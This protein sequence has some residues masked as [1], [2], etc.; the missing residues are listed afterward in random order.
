MDGWSI[1]RLQVPSKCCS[2]TLRNRQLPISGQF[3]STCYEMPKLIRCQL[4]V[5]SDES[6]PCACSRSHNM[7]KT[8]LNMFKWKISDEFRKQHVVLNA[9]HSGLRLLR[10]PGRDGPQDF[11][12]PFSRWSNFASAFQPWALGFARPFA[13]G[14]PTR[15]WCTERCLS[16][17]GPGINLQQT[18]VGL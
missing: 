2:N 14:F 6:R 3:F 1:P 18:P 7:Y 10:C 4:W 8:R 9:F 11:Q 15:R 16:W 17:H 12:L 13:Q 5:S